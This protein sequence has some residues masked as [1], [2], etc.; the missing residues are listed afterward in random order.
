MNCME[1]SSVGTPWDSSS[2]IPFSYFGF[3][4]VN[5]AATAKAAQSVSPAKASGFFR[6]AD[7]YREVFHRLLPRSE[8]RTHR[9]RSFRQIGGLRAPGTRRKSRVRGDGGREGPDS[10][11]GDFRGGGVRP[12][13]SQ[14]RHQPQVFL[15][16]ERAENIGHK[17]M[18]HARRTSWV[19]ADR[20]TTC[21]TLYG[22]GTGKRSGGARRQV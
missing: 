19:L 16:H 13:Q 20:F 14:L 12:R 9:A 1:G 11:G 22:Q 17:L 10:P 21:E 4:P 3:A 18:R 2:R 7:G 6:P 8:G 15:N 5:V